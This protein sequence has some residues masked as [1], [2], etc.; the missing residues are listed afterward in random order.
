MADRLLNSW[1]EIAQYLGRGVRTVQRWESELALP[2]RRPHGR[3][4]SAVIALSTEIDAWLLKSAQRER[5][6]KNAQPNRERLRHRKDVLERNLAAL[7]S[8]VEIMQ[9]QL[10]V[11]MALRDKVAQQLAAHK[12]MA[13]NGANGHAQRR[14]D[15]VA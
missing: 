7:A 5:A 8:N 13:Q 2:V 1:K 14:S 15:H 10:D 3:D 4:R 12:V 9:K 6:R 11:A